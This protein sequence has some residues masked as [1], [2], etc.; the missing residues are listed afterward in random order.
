MAEN[1]EVSFRPIRAEPYDDVIE[2]NSSN[3]TFYIRVRATLAEY[4]VK[5]QEY[6]DFGF[7]TVKEESRK[8]FLLRNVGEVDA[9]FE[10]Q[11]EP[12]F[13]LEAGDGILA[14]APA[15]KGF[16]GT[17]PPKRDAR[18][19]LL[20]T[21]LDASVFVGTVVCKQ[22]AGRPALVMRISGIGKLPFVQA[23]A[24]SLDFGSVLTGQ[25]RDLELVLTNTTLVP[26]SVALR[27][28]PAGRDPVFAFRGAAW[29]LPADSSLA[30]T[31]TYRPAATGSFDCEY[32]DLETPG[33][34]CPRV[35][36]RGCAE[37]HDVR[38]APA[39]VS[40]GNLPLGRLALRTVELINRFIDQPPL[41]P[42]PSPSFPSSLLRVSCSPSF[43]WGVD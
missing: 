40:F 17:L 37:P 32:F 26:V 43:P 35:C 36:L 34:N 14:A 30:V 18:V 39:A 23:S 25:S 22:P 16:S 29:R 33:G 42:S 1:I 8:H 20:F 21:P 10:L 38:A 31:A 9:P 24:P 27:P 4:G 11:V 3:G 6:L 19:A 13:A 12:P 41:F 7:S 5:M 2:F 28:L 15:P